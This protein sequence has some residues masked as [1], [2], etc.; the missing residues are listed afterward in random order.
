MDILLALN[1]HIQPHWELQGIVRVSWEAETVINEQEFVR[2]VS[3]AVE[4]LLSS[5]YRPTI[6]IDQ[7]KGSFARVLVHTEPLKFFI[8]VN[9]AIQSV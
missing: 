8:C 5:F 1:F 7:A 6:F 4:N 9:V 2:S 3:I